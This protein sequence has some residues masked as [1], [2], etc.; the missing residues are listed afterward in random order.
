MAAPIVGEKIMGAL[1]DQAL[2][3]L[4]H[5]SIGRAPGRG[6]LVRGVA[7]ADPPSCAC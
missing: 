1:I 4:K 5:L 3:I 2:G 6:F 7:G